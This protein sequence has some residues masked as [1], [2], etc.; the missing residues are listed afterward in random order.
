MLLFAP[1]LLT[2]GLVWVF[3]R[4]EDQGNA[5]AVL[6]RLVQQSVRIPD[7]RYDH[8][9]GA[10]LMTLTIACMLAAGSITVLFRRDSVLGSLTK[11][12][13]QK[14]RSD[15]FVDEEALEDIGYLGEQGASGSEKTRVL[16]SLDTLIKSVQ[17]HGEY[18]GDGG[19]EPLLELIE[20]T[21]RSD[22]DIDDLLYGIEIIG[23]ATETLRR[24]E[25]VSSHDV[26]LCLIRVQ[27]LGM[28]AL[29]ID[30]DKAAFQVLDTVAPLMQTS[31]GVSESSSWVVFGLGA[32]AM[33][34]KL[35]GFGVAALSALEGL[36]GREFTSSKKVPAAY[37]GLVAHFWAGGRAAQ[38]RARQSIEG[39]GLLSSLR[40]HVETSHRHLVWRTQFETADKLDAMLADVVRLEMG[41]TPSSLSSP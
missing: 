23:K 40:E 5:V 3:D 10:F 31:G 19:L 1:V 24:L 14:L 28:Q 41:P 21:L 30:S 15:G 7:P 18:E 35:Y 4:C 25:L 20:A 37:L 8:L 34:R 9:M 33:G 2:L 11:Q 36:A 32:A 26:S 16:E 13:M 22:T 29:N 17:A 39:M 27:Q 38:G 12:C 6:M